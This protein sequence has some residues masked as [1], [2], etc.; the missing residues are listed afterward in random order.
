[1]DEGLLSREGRRKRL[2]WVLMIC[3]A[4]PATSG[5]RRRKEAGLLLRLARTRR[6][7][8]GPPVS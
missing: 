4:L 3:L 5:V 2:C 8:W 1:M 7:E 6:S